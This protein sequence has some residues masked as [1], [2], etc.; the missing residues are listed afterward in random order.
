LRRPAAARVSLGLDQPFANRFGTWAFATL[1]GH[2]GNSLFSGQS[3]V[4]MIAQHIPPT[5]S[6]M[7]LTLLI[8]VS[9]AVPLGVVAAAR[10]GSWTALRGVFLRPIGLFANNA[11]SCS[12]GEQPTR[13]SRASG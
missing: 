3:I 8:S 4:S 10:Q 9:V 6:L 2:L 1:Q 5:L 13:L 7:I 11:T 12:S